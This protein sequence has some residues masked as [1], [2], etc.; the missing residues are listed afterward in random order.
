VHLSS[1]G[2]NDAMSSFTSSP[3]GLGKPSGLANAILET[4]DLA[5]SPLWERGMVLVLGLG[6]FVEP[7]F[8]GTENSILAVLT[9]GTVNSLPPASALTTPVNVVVL[10]NMVCR[11]VRLPHLPVCGSRCVEAG[12]GKARMMS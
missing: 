11:T 9:G 2:A 4:E 12:C 3:R 8:V 10:E 6:S 7:C 1:L 5:L